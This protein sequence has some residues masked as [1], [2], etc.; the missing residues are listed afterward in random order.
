MFCVASSKRQYDV[1]SSRPWALLSSS[2]SEF[3]RVAHSAAVLVRQCWLCQQCAARCLKW[4]AL[5]VKARVLEVALVSM[6]SIVS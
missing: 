4:L 2:R 3:P 5:F 6:S 1:H